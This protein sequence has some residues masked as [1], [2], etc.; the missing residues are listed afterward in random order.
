MLMLH[1]SMN[2]SGMSSM[3]DVKTVPVPAGGEVKF[4]PGGYHLMCMNPAP[5]MKPGGMVSVTL[6][7][8]DKSE[9]K[10]EFAVKN[11][12]GK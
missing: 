3:E 2:M 11:A 10:T 4:A 9:V 7:F 12:Q 1:Q 6:Q 8:S 5:A